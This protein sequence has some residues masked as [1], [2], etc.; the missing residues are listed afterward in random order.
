[1]HDN[2]NMAYSMTYLC[3]MFSSCSYILLHG[4]IYVQKEE[5]LAMQPGIYVFMHELCIIPLL[6]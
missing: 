2:D 4:C 1:M 6:L 5:R 3:P